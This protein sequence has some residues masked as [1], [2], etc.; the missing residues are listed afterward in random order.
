MDGKCGLGLNGTSR[1][2]RPDD[3]RAKQTQLCQN[4]RQG[5]VGTGRKARERS[6]RQRGHR[7]KRA[8]EAIDLAHREEKRANEATHL[9]HREEKRANEATEGNPKDGGLSFERCDGTNPI[10]RFCSPRGSIPTSYAVR[11]RIGFAHSIDKDYDNPASILG[12][13]FRR[14]GATHR[15]EPMRTPLGCTQTPLTANAPRS[16]CVSPC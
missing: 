7:K 6:H 3:E 14:V 11:P 10:S 16:G 5:H 15:C 2:D 4:G 9:A 1:S 8:N 13:R 12:R